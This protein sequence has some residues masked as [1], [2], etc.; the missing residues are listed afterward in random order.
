MKKIGFQIHSLGCKVNQ[1]DG[2]V[3]KRE[4]ENRGFVVDKKKP[5]LIIINTCT[6]TKTAI[7]KDKRLINKYQR[8]FPKSKLVIMGCWPQTDNGA[9]NKIG[10][11]II[12]WGVG[13]IDKLINK[14]ISLYPKKVIK[15]KEIMET[16]LLAPLERSRY[17][18]KIG[19]GCN[20]FCSYC[21]IPF[22]R[23]RLKSRSAKE[24][25]S[26]IEEA[27]EA[28]FREI[29]LSG[30]HLGKYG[31]DKKGKNLVS[32]IKEILKI[33][34]LGRIRLSSIEVNEVTTELIKLMK[35][36]RKICRHLHISL[37]SGSN[38]ILKAMNRP[39]SKE[40][41]RKKVLQLRR[42]MPDIA[43]TTDI[44]IG[45]PGETEKDFQETYS[46]VKEISFSKIHVF[47]FS[48]HEKT[49]AY[50]MENKVKQ[51]DIKERSKK[52]RAL[53]TK[54][55]D[56][57]KKKILALYKNKKLSLVIE[58]QE[59]NKFKCKTEFYFDLHLNQKEL[60]KNTLA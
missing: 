27:T 37:Q 22:A 13:K 8:E 54:L 56:Q 17:F 46:F 14:I 10:K 2:A 51:V 41:F 4:L 20:Q 42:V 29:V 21:I 36:N 26:E 24:I 28:G 1:Y 58:H 38:K 39:Y 44:I 7:T 50:K 31:E 19:D 60:T 25:I 43:I 18:I 45:F 40:Y 16:G 32:L 6:V 15:D 53:S 12:L 23:G 9:S 57:Y 47:S 34:N 5:E 59:K 11:D 48:A 49:L 52:L 3:I 55:E 30:I 33:E 35:G